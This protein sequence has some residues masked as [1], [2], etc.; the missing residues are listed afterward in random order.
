MSMHTDK[1]RATARR[2]GGFAGNDRNAHLWDFSKRELVEIAL[3]LA[4]S[5]TGT[6]D[7]S[8]ETGLAERRLME[9]YDALR[10]NGI[11]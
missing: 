1:A 4:A 10:A 11:I 3:H 6:Y 9:E 5:L 8:L 7:E 2:R